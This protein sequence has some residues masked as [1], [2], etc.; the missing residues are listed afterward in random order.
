MYQFDSL[1]A[2]FASLGIANGLLFGGYLLRQARS[3]P[4]DSNRYLGWFIFLL[5]LRFAITTVHYFYRSPLADWADWG[6]VLN[7]CLGPSFV[8]YVLS[9]FKTPPARAFFRLHLI[10]ALVLLGL[11]LLGRRVFSPAPFFEPFNDGWFL[12]NQLTLLH[13]ILYLV[14]G[15]RLFLS[16]LAKKRAEGI[17]TRKVQQWMFGLLFFLSVL[18]L[19]YSFNNAKLLC[20]IFCPL[21]YTIIVYAIL[22]FFIKNSALLQKGYGL[23]GN[24]VSVLKSE[25]I[26]QIRENLQKLLAEKGVF[27]NPELTLDKL[28]QQL[29]ISPHALS[30]YINTYE[31]SNFSDWLNRHRVEYACY[32]LLDPQCTH[33]KIAAV[34]FDSGFNTL[35]VFNVAFKKVMGVTPSAFRRMGDLGTMKK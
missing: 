22:A 6:L 7:L 30:H 25:K 32:L 17:D 12:I 3:V 21:F 20:V 13:W 8:V 28:A 2:A 34:A 16:E 19:G 10:P 11:S 31:G 24:K 1:F 27:L 9:V 23:E 4:Q 26:P 5:S 18:I 14:Y 29:D 35:S 33:L 15:Y